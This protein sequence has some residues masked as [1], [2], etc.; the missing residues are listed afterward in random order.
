MSAIVDSE[1]TIVDKEPTTLDELTPDWKIYQLKRG[2]R[3][4]NDDKLCAWRAAE[5]GR[6]A[7]K[8]LDLGAGIGSVGL[9]C[10]WRLDDTASL[11][12]VEAQSISA[13]LLRKSIE[14]N[15]L[16]S[17][18][19]VVEEDLRNYHSD[20][21]KF[22]LIS[23]S[24]PYLPETDGI[25]SS[26]PQKAHCRFELR[27]GIDDYCA[28]AARCLS[29][30][31]VFVFVMAAQDPRCLSAPQKYFDIIERYD[32]RFKGDRENPMISTIVCRWSSSPKFCDH[33]E[34]VL[35]DV[36][37]RRSLQYRAWQ[38]FMALKPGTVSL[39]DLEHALTNL[40]R[41]TDRFIHDH[42]HDADLRSAIASALALGIRPTNGSI[43]LRD[44]LASLSSSPP[45]S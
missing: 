44:A 18:V 35:R 8:Y 42:S 39:S 25:L 27:G 14:Y 5:H 41:A 16:T 26:H 31:G 9:T 33:R 15:K 43:E 29:N 30:D 1:P 45:E 22:D 32:Y 34:L 3:F 2:H 23:G 20:D 10:L 24:P 19:R 17:R 21:D 7:R 37:G 28:T 38:E 12:C 11:V 6:D 4:S 36:D 13:T 40:R